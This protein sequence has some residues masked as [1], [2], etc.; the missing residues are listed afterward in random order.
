[1]KRADDKAIDWRACLLF[2]D[3]HLAVIDK[4][5]GVLSQKDKSGDLDLAELLAAYWKSAGEKTAFLAPV[6]RL[7]RNTSGAI[8]LA[9]SSAAA[10]KLTSSLRA[11]DIGRV[12]FAAVKGDP[13]E[14]GTISAPLAK[15]EAENKSE[16]SERG[17]AAITHFRRT[18]KLAATSLVEVELET[19]RSHQIRAH[20]AHIRCPLLGDKK[21]AKAPWNQ[22]FHR[23]ALHAQAI[24]FPHPVT[25]KP[26][27]FAAPLPADLRELIGRI[28]G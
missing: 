3:A 23:P 11:G 25:G 22:I 13:G 2:V 26:L 27:H 18:K 4:P 28:G 20:F 10:A 1:M 5:A 7:D 8:L 17:R 15:D 16:V 6:H 9:R 24:R 21:Y 12:Y 19:G 14:N